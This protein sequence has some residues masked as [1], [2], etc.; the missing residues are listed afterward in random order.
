MAEGDCSKKQRYR[1]DRSKVNSCC[2]SRNGN[3]TNYSTALALFC[4]PVLPPQ[5]PTDNVPQSS[6]CGRSKHRLIQ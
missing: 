1:R 4:H 6:P 5:K 3:W 2:H